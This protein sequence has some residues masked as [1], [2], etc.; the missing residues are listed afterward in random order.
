[1]CLHQEGRAE[2]VATRDIAAGEEVYVD[3]GKWYWA[4]SKTLPSR[5]KVKI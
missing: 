3:Y 1:M 4:G 5:L 2:V